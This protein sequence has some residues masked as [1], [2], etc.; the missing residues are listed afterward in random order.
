MD[1]LKT[2]PVCFEDFDADPSAIAT[3]KR[4]TSRLP[5]YSA[6]CTDKICCSCLCQMRLA[7]I[8]S[9]KTKLPVWFSCPVCGLA[10]AFRVGSYDVDFHSCEALRLVEEL[11]AKNAGLMLKVRRLEDGNDAA[12]AVGQVV[13]VSSS[14]DNGTKAVSAEA[15]AELVASAASA[16]SSA[17]AA[18]TAAATAAEAAAAA[19]KQLI[20][21][22]TKRPF[23]PNRDLI[24]KDGEESGALSIHEDEEESIALPPF[25]KRARKQRRTIPH[26]T[27]TS[28]SSLKFGSAKVATVAQ[29]SRPERTR[30][31][32]EQSVGWKAGEDYT[33]ISSRK[34]AW[35]KASGPVTTPRRLSSAAST[36]GDLTTD[37]QEIDNDRTI[38][39]KHNDVAATG[40][41]SRYRLGQHIKK[42]FRGHGTYR[43]KIT[44]LPTLCF[45][46][47]RVLYDDGD[48]EDIHIATIYRYI[49]CGRLCSVHGCKKYSEGRRCQF[50]CRRHFKEAR[51]A[52]SVTRGHSKPSKAVR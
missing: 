51:S 45:P 42:T 21:V 23:D 36:S 17:A 4:P 47:Y 18:A 40:C 9:S 7:R 49:D 32:P 13:D 2:C 29:S 27:S 15:A 28:Y 25:A 26:S 19:T 11:E 5:L 48:E 1:R 10:K 50:M 6:V 37:M 24:G 44:A 41:A 43:G 46:W 35:H 39:N 38:S 31:A 22:G 52:N 3:E 8:K 16:A 33:E 30:R 20:G 12:V 34:A 14:G